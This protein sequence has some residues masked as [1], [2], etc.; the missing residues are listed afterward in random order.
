MSNEVKSL[1]IPDVFKPLAITIA[2]ESEKELAAF[3][4]LFNHAYLQEATVG[5]TAAEK[6][7]ES[8]LVAHGRHPDYHKYHSAICSKMRF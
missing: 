2:F 5:E 1:P 8:L 4:S 3:Y 6:I 7:K